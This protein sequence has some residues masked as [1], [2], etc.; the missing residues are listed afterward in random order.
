MVGDKLGDKIL[1]DR[2]GNLFNKEAVIN[3]LLEKR[4]ET[5]RHIR[6]LKDV[7]E[8]NFT[9]NPNHQEQKTGASRAIC[10]RWRM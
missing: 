10:M 2:L 9:L 1:I 4:G 6:S 3:H 5:F 8:P 7:V